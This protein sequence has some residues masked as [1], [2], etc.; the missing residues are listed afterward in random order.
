M[1][2]IDDAFDKL[3]SNLEITQT[4]TGSRCHSTQLDS[5]TH[6]G[7]LDAVGHF[8][9]GSYERKTK[10][11][12]LKDV[13]IF[14]VIDPAGPRGGLRIAPELQRFPLCAT[15]CPPAGAI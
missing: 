4:E 12:K 5:R 9:T 7:V 15:Y 13:D 8:L 10:T 2:Y 14:V 1:S 11:K 3:K 6:R